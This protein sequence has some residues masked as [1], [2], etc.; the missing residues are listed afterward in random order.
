VNEVNL[1]NVRHEASRL[2]ENKE[3]E[4]LR[5]KINEFES[6]R[7]RSETCTGA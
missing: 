2:L 6:N 1:N 3:R 7:I 5:D 4:Y